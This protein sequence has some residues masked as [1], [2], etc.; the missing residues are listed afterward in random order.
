M[1]DKFFSKKIKN[2]LDLIRFEKPIGFLL[3]MW[4]CWFALTRVTHEQSSIF[5]YYIYF[6]IGS[7][8]MR[9][10]GCIIN[11]IIDIDLD[12]K[13]E[14]TSNRPLVSKKVSLK[15]AVLLLFLLL[16]CS[17]LIL[18]NFSFNAVIS[19]LVSLPLIILYPLMKR[20]THWPQIFLGLIFNWGVIIV[21]VEFFNFINYDLL[22]LYIGCIFWTLAYDTIYAYQ[23]R[24]DDIKSNIKSTAILFGSKGGI[25]VKFFYNIFFVSIA[26]L[27]FKSSGSNVSLIVIIIFI[28]AINIYLNKWKLESASSSNYYFKFNNLIGLFCFCFL[29]MF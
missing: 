17:F 18:I 20:Y 5:Y 25:V 12:K 6:L 7:F 1:L 27:G 24:M 8:L 26:Y 2:L 14:R 4:P 28:F 22:I 9:S 10:A 29:L 11:D 16:L 23:D 21:L 19:G 15:E 3:L 13:V